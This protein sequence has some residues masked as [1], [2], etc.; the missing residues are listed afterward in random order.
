MKNIVSKI[1]LIFL[2]IGLF[3]IFTF[4]TFFSWEKKEIS[5]PDFNI[6]KIWEEVL[7]WSISDKIDFY[8]TIYSKNKNYK[9]TKNNILF[10]TWVY[11]I[12]SRD[13]FS[14]INLDMWDNNVLL[15]WG[16]IVYI[17]NNP[18]YKKII[19]FN[20]KIKVN[21]LNKNTNKKSVEV[22][23]YPHMSF[24]FKP[25]RFF[26]EEKADS[27]R[28]SQLWD[29][30]YFNQ[31]FS[32][33]INWDNNTFIKKNKI[34]FLSQSLQNIIKNQK[35]YSNQLEE[36][37]N[38]NF[39][40]IDSFYIERYFS[41][42]YNNRKKIIYYKNKTLNLLIELLNSND[43]K[44]VFE[45][46]KNIE[47]IKELDLEESNKMKEFTKEI[48]YLVSYN[49]WKDS[50]SIQ[51]SYDLLIS[52][53]FKINDN[54]KIKLTKDVDRYNYLWDFTKYLNL[55]VLDIENKS[56][57]DIDKQYYILFKQNLLVSNLSNLDIEQ[58]Y[59]DIL[60]K[61]FT[62]YSR[63]I[64]K[65]ISVKN[66]DE[67]I[68]NIKY[69]IN[70]LEKIS[71]SFEYRYFEEGRNSQ[72][73][74]T[75]KGKNNIKNILL[76]EKS[77]ENIFEKYKKSTTYLEQNLY[78]YNPIIVRY[79]S[80]KKE[81][82][83]YI[84]ALTSYSL[85]KKKYSKV[86]IE[87]TK[88]KIY[89]DQEDILTKDKFINYISQFSWINLSSI[90]VEINEDFYK[91]NN[92]SINW[93]DF[94]FELLPYSWNIIQ[95]IVYKKN[96][97]YKN[98]REK[99]FYTHI[100]STSYAL[101]KDKEKY[102]ELF[103]KAKNEDKEKY[104]F[105]NYFRNT[106]FLSEDKNKEIYEEQSNSN[107]DDEIIQ[108]FKR[109][110]LLW[111]KWEFRNIKNTLNLN[112]SNLDVK[113]KTWKIFLIKILNSELRVIIKENNRNINYWA[114]FNSD[115]KLEN[116]R[117]YFYNIKLEPF[118]KKN[119]SDKREL[120][121]NVKFKLSWKIE[122]ADFEKQ[123][124]KLFLQIPEINKKYLELSNSKKITQITYSIVT[125]KYYFK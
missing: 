22:Y 11:L 124:K 103:E 77:I 112:Y 110:K 70:L 8:T 31:N 85:Y 16:W 5:K 84:S 28:V 14:T 55:S 4:Y 114:V 25:Y 59:Y 33:I 66:R 69:N 71:S 1:I 63:N 93:R 97:G 99:G 56:L 105:S 125:G 72:N 7:N 118:I 53:M 76:I 20:N 75:F 87:L 111:N 49:L 107:Q 42:F 6:S 104:N 57:E 13:I 46:L 15:K 67:F 50:D 65:N 23:L 48:F 43:A 74:L 35:K 82:K 52:R 68:V 18:K 26:K 98:I 36:L 41:L 88:V 92:I 115:Y 116:N 79:T 12:D 100:E 80:I 90:D 120:F 122:L 17:D 21:F 73:L 108:T 109:A 96:W 91:I 19:S 2:F 78:K 81:L 9:A 95:D 38:I 121:P 94:S 54:R 29:L 117:H 61:W 47:L 30:K 40:N 27:L 45:I 58:K 10:W 83:E 89:E 51:N 119:S 123:I 106:L 24:W 32:E 64:E 113:R 102:R 3:F 37:K 86:N 39:W 44:T 62:S 101:D 60:L 34:S